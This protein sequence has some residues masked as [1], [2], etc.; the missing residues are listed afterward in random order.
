MYIYIHVY[1]CIHIHMYVCFVEV[2][3]AAAGAFF[4][5]KM[6]LLS[7]MCQL[8]S[9][10]SARGVKTGRP[11]V[12]LTQGMARTFPYKVHPPGIIMTCRVAV[13]Q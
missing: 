1:K 8:S 2:F 3:S 13:W 12:A 10:H 7:G 5:A 9:T 6:A 11:H 4:S